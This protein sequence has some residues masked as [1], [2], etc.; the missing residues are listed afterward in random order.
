MN[1]H[2]LMTHLLKVINTPLYTTTAMNNDAFLRQMRG[3]N[4]NEGEVIFSLENDY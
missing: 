4:K 2:N 3:P 1:Q